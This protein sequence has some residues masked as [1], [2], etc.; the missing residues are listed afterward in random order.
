MALTSISM[1]EVGTLSLSPSPSLFCWSKGTSTILVLLDQ[2]T[3]VERSEVK[4]FLANII[5]SGPMQFCHQY[6][7]AT[8][9]IL[10]LILPCPKPGQVS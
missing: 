8:N 10:P 2:I 4:E 9:T 1:S 7:T 3:S 5:E 6:N